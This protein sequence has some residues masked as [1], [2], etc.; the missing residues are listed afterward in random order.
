[1]KMGQSGTVRDGITGMA[2][3][4]DRIQAAMRALDLIL[5]EPGGCD[6]DWETHLRRLAI[7]AIEAGKAS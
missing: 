3:S 6:E 7:A 1:M 5:D 2:V 4:E